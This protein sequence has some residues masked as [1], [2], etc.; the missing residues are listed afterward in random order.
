MYIFE[1]VHESY[2]EF[3]TTIIVYQFHDIS[4]S[5]VLTKVTQ[6]RSLAPSVVARYR[7]SEIFYC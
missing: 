7:N 1:A 6:V 3:G 4:Q 2:H 5:I